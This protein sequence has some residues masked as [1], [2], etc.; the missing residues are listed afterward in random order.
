MNRS[1]VAACM[2][3]RLNWFATAIFSQDEFD[4]DGISDDWWENEQPH[5]VTAQW[6]HRNSVVDLKNAERL[7]WW[8]LQKVMKLDRSKR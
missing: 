5:L 8:R 6:H 4:R 7:A 1:F 2:S 3:T